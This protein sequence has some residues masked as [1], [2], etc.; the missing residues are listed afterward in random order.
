MPYVAS[1][2]FGS[3]VSEKRRWKNASTFRTFPEPIFRRCMYVCAV[4]RIP[5]SPFRRIQQLRCGSKVERSRDRPEQRE[6][7]KRDTFCCVNRKL[8]LLQ[9]CTPCRRTKISTFFDQLV[10]LSIFASDRQRS[11]SKN[12][13]KQT[14]FCRCATSELHMYCH[15]V[16]VSSSVSLWPAEVI[17]DGRIIQHTHP[18]RLLLRNPDAV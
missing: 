7:G 10:L 15:C 6:K 9:R 16:I 4:C 17:A 5:F 14:F 1:L 3:L 2:F 13:P 8:V 11:A 18:F 12:R